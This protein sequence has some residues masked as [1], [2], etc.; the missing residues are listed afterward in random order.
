MAV[1]R[2][3]LLGLERAYWEAIRK[4]DGRSAERLTDDECVIVGA[5]GASTFKPSD[6]AAMLQGGGWEITGF[7]LD[8]ETLQIRSIGDAAI[9]A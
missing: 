4:K 2:D 5:G 1:S 7:E 3:E 8:E 9:V 6:M